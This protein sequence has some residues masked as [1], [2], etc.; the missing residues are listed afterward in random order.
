MIAN[1]PAAEDMIEPRTSTWDRLSPALEAYLARASEEAALAAEWVPPLARALGEGRSCLELDRAQ[2][3]ALAATTS[4]KLISRPGESK[5][6]II[7]HQRLYFH[8][9]WSA[10]VL[11][12]DR[13]TQLARH[14]FALES[15]KLP[16]SFGLTETQSA[17]VHHALSHGLTLLSG[18]PGT[19]KTLT[20]AAIVEASL[21]SETGD[22]C[23]SIGLAA[24]TGKAAARMA[25]LLDRRSGTVPESLPKVSTLHRLLGADASGRHFQFGRNRSLPLDMLIVDEVSMIDLSLMARLLEAIDPSRTRLVLAGDSDQLA[26]VE[27]GAVLGDLTRIATDSNSLL[28]PGFFRLKEV[29]RSSPG[30]QAIAELLRDGDR[31]GLNDQVDGNWSDF[32]LVEPGST[33][34]TLEY[35][36]PLIRGGFEP[37]D[38][39]NP[40]DQSMSPFRILC[41]S[42]YG[43]LGMEAINRFAID[44]LQE[45]GV[46]GRRG[47]FWVGIPIIITRNDYGLELFNGDTGWILEGADGRPE[48]LISATGG[49]RRL[50]AERLA[51][52]EPAYALTVHRAQGSEFDRIALVLSPRQEDF[53]TR[54]LLYTAVSRARSRAEIIGPREALLT[55]STRRTLRPSGLFARMT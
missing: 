48:A 47:G 12:A 35:L 34:A 23:L 54:E 10:E 45:E 7:E 33:S 37:P 46:V 36:L 24:P 32:A 4:G 27:A 40:A 22:S 50:P 19:G 26:S 30:I 38:C 11:I 5:P 16:D 53:L 42:R 49:I 31:S 6:L 17:A 41:P 44:R 15:P 25:E 18:A 52:W 14:S 43:P 1:A 39:E 3:A 9:Y 13:L 2:F 51:E 8:R 21:I 28:A 29:F 55:G 20:I